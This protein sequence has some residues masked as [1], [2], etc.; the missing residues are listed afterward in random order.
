M[1]S[2]TLVLLAALGAAGCIEDPQQR[3]VEV[4]PREGG[5]GDQGLRVDARP[6]DGAVPDVALADRGPVD[7]APPAEAACVV[8]V[9]VVDGAGSAPVD[10]QLAPADAP[11]CEV[12]A[13][14]LCGLVPDVD[15]EECHWMIA[16]P[17]A[18][19]NLSD[20]CNG[21]RSLDDLLRRESWLMGAGPAKFELEWTPGCADH[22]A[23]F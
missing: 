5:V 13:D 11:S 1:N 4:E 6:L 9:A 22:V 18:L 8:N 21:V 16:E 17:R 3:T 10:C 19:E 15:P 23:T 12:L 7:A 2:R 20:W 14:C